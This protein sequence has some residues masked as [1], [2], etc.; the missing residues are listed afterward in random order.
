VTFFDT[1]LFQ[2]YF[3]WTKL[4]KAT[5]KKIEADEYRKPEPVAIL[6]QRAILY[7]KA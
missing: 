1:Q 3:Q 2:D 6:K 5:L 4:T 7:T